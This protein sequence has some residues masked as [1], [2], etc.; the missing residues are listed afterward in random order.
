MKNRGI[1]DVCFNPASY[2]VFLHVHGYTAVHD[3]ILQTI[4]QLT[5]HPRDHVGRS[6]GLR[7]RMCDHDAEWGCR[8][9]GCR[10][11]LGT[12]GQILCRVADIRSHVLCSP[13]S[14]TQ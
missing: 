14:L 10:D 2:R 1:T 12:F 13:V 5:H 4:L 9:G 7:L 6:A 11:P 8:P 3:G